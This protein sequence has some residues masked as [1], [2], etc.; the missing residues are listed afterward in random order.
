M[1]FF[2]CAA[3]K[4]RREFKAST[5]KTAKNAGCALSFSR[6]ATAPSRREP[7]FVHVFSLC[8]K[9]TKG[10]FRTSKA[11]ICTFFLCGSA[12]RR[13]APSSGRKVARVSVTEGACE[14]EGR[15]KAE[16]FRRFSVNPS[17]A[18]RQLPLHKGAMG[19]CKFR[20][21]AAEKAKGKFKVSAPKTA[22]KQKLRT[23][24]Q[25]LRDSSLSEG[26][27]VCAIFRLCAAKKNNRKI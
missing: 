27:F 16:V 25:S 23:L 20:R 18:P 11:K 5:P 6:F 19:C 21:C 26:A 14:T 12:V 2:L 22:E 10:I 1:C 15:Q 13:Y 4:T 24:L 7:L 9:K 3:E 8:R 17:G